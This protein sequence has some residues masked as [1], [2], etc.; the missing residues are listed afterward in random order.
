ARGAVFGSE[1]SGGRARGGAARLAD[2]G[3]AGAASAGRDAG[4]DGDARV[5]SGGVCT[6]GPRR[7]KRQELLF[8]WRASARAYG[9]RD[10]AAAR[11]D[12]ERQGAGG[13]RAAAGERVSS[14]SEGVHRK[15]SVARIIAFFAGRPRREGRGAQG[16]PRA[17]E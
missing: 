1:S 7:G 15:E 8:F 4:V 11:G 17:R 14:A 2:T 3:G 13:S 5:R 16:S 6:A 10:G 9:G 12:R